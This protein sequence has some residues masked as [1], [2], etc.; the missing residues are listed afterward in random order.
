MNKSLKI[1][2]LSLSLIYCA[3][4][5]NAEDQMIYKWIDEHNIAH[6][7]QLKPN[8]NKFIEIPITNINR[9]I[10]TANELNTQNNEFDISINVIN[11]EDEQNAIKAVMAKHC[12]KARE[13]IRTLIA[14]DHVKYTDNNGK[15]KLLSESEKKQK[16]ILSEK[17]VAVYCKK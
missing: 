4:A 17:Q 10:K 8:H 13:D 16:L 1:R 2:F 6:F 7:S 14:F 9:N 12:E 11:Q 5:S 3:F 15:V